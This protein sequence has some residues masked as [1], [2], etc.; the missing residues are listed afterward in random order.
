MA[1]S[2]N[3]VVTPQE[4]NAKAI[5]F[6]SANGTV[7]QDLFVA[8]A[9]DGSKVTAIN[10]AST[11]TLARILRIR[12]HDGVTAFFEAAFSIPAATGTDGSA[13]AINILNSDRWPA[14]PIDMEGNRYI[15]VAAGHKLTAVLTANTSGGTVIDVKA[16]GRNY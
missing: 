2:Q 1:I 10:V 6:T 16:R 7:E 3:Q 8:D 13:A 11:D 15:E 4:V 5:Q 9:T 12:Y 14:G